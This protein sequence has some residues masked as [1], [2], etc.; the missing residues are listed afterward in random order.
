[1]A[2]SGCFELGAEILNFDYLCRTSKQSQQ[3]GICVLQTPPANVGI[4]GF[5]FL[6]KEY[7]KNHRQP[8]DV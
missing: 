4:L 8:D 2:V 6:C 5:A 7:Y 3:L 1:M